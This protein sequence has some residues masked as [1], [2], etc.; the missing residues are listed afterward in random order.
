MVSESTSKIACF[1]LTTFLL[2]VIGVILAATLHTNPTNGNV[3]LLA[4]HLKVV[5]Q[6][7]SNLAEAEAARELMAKQIASLISTNADIAAAASAALTAEVTNLTVEV[8]KNANL[9]STNADIAA[10]ASAALT[11]EVTKSELQMTANKDDIDAKLGD[12]SLL[13]DTGEIRHLID[14]KITFTSVILAN[15]AAAAAASAALTVKVTKNAVDIAVHRRSWGALDLSP[16]AKT[17]NLPPAV[18][19]SPYAKT[20]DLPPAVD[21]SSYAKRA[22]LPTVLSGGVKITP[23]AVDLSSYAKTADLNQRA[24]SLDDN[25]CSSNR[26]IEFVGC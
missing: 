26:R 7:A 14:G 22:D 17:A 25:L 23:L 1:N 6:M 24:T 12:V 11:V 19:L 15:A 3:K 13:A 20:A 16:Y 10:A 4:D 8:T 2:A 9:I 5:E 21:L 18:D